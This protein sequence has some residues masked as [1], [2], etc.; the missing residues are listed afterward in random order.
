VL[1]E[2]GSGK[3]TLAVALLRLLPGNGKFQRGGVYVRGQDLLGAEPRT[4]ERIRGARIAL[5]FQEP[6][7][8]PLHPTI[9]IGEQISDVLPRTNR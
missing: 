1:G 4:L 8:C 6:S 5:I 2:S 9:R 3:S 7:A